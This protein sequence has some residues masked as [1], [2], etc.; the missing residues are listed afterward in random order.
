MK[1][2]NCPDKDVSEVVGEKVCTTTKCSNLV[3][4]HSEGMIYCKLEDNMEG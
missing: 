4:D 2:P 1:C 3:M